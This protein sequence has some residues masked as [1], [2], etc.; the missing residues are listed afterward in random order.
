M[1]SNAPKSVDR[2]IRSF[3]KITPKA[4]AKRIDTYRIGVAMLTK[5]SLSATRKNMNE[6]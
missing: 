4:I 5:T 1:M 3:R 2:L 6:R